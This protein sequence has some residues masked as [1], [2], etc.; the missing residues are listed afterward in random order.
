[1]HLS[2]SADLDHVTGACQQLLAAITL[3]VDHMAVELALTEGLNNAI[4][5][6]NQMRPDTIVK[7]QL[8]SQTNTVTCVITDAAS[9]LCDD[10]LN[11]PLADLD[12]TS[13]RGLALIK[14]LANDARIVD[15]SLHMTFIALPPT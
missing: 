5:H 8:L 9:R 13:G 15:G 2:I 3:P 10:M 6:G 4:V 7:I 11:A 14:N 12:A 1:M